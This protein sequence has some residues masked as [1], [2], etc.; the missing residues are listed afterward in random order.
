M[1]Y[2]LGAHAE[3]LDLMAKGVSARFLE[4]LVDIIREHGDVTSGYGRMLDGDTMRV[5]GPLHGYLLRTESLLVSSKDDYAIKGCYIELSQEEAHARYRTAQARGCLRTFCLP[6]AS[7]GV[8]VLRFTWGIRL[9]DMA[10][11]IYQHGV[12]TVGYPAYDSVTL[13]DST[14]TA[15]PYKLRSHGIVFFR[16]VWGY[17]GGIVTIRGEEQNTYY[18]L[19]ESML[20]DTFVSEYSGYRY[21]LD[22][23]LELEDGHVIATWER[24]HA[25]RCEGCGK[26]CLPVDDTCLCRECYE[27]MPRTV[28]PICGLHT[29][30][31]SG[32]H[33]SCLTQICSYHQSHCYERKHFTA[34]D[35]VY[36][37]G[38]ENELIF[39]SDYARGEYVKAMRETFPQAFN[40]ERDGSLNSHGVETISEIFDWEYLTEHCIF[41]RIASIMREH[42]GH[43]DDSTGLHVHI[44]RDAFA[45]DD[46]I[47]AWLCLINRQD[48][49][50]I[51]T[52]GSGRKAGKRYYC[53]RCS[54][55]GEDTEIDDYT[56]HGGCVTVGDHTCEIRCF[57]ATSTAGG[58]KKAVAVAIALVDITLH[59]SVAEVMEWTLGE[60]H[61]RMADSLKYAG[62]AFKN[63]AKRAGKEI[64]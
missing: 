31:P 5:E 61:R 12:Y 64:N 30:H 3:G 21:F 28:C 38:F 17:E 60:I 50:D 42:R 26:L 41:E 8:L 1:L 18:T 19:P 24:D 40:F 11:A 55:Y 48:M 36:T 37:L 34:S 59:A 33:P 53:G 9:V 46:H 16:G 13:G 29:I 54:T 15:S 35:S 62:Y 49:Y 58:M 10:D 63:Y 57:K 56:S 2:S 20:S 4:A 27:A 39:P 32:Y 51:L 47:I 52:L 23:R 45:D 22:D 14:Y 44:S 43:A 25:V 6:C 7:R